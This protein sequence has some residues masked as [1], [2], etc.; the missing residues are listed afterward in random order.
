MKGSTNASE[1]GVGMRPIC[2]TLR[3]GV[4]VA[5]QG[6]VEENPNGSI[7]IHDMRGVKTIYPKDEFR[8]WHFEGGSTLHS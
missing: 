3:D 6:W 5:Y 2:L 7:T 4:G 8:E 1:N